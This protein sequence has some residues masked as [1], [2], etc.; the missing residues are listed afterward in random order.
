MAV[1]YREAIVRKTF[2]YRTGAVSKGCAM[3]PLGDLASLASLR[4]FTVDKHS[5]MNGE[6]GPQKRE[7]RIGCNH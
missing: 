3:D 1:V 7:A 6:V 4:T 2:L 5:C